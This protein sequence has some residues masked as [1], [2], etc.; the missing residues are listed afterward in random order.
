[1]KILIADDDNSARFYLEIMLKKWGYEVVIAKDGNSA[2]EILQ[3]KSTP[4]LAILDW[5]MP[6]MSGI[7]ICS[8]IRQLDH[9]KQLYILL[10]TAK[11][12]KEDIIAGLQ[13]GAD[14]YVTKP[15]DRDI[16][17][18][19]ILV[20]VRL[21]TLQDHLAQHLE[22]LQQALAKVNKLQGLVPI[23]SYCKKIRDDKNYWHQV[24]QYISEHSGAQFSH[25]ICPECK[26][27]VL[28]EMG[29]RKL[30]KHDNGESS[31]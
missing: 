29:S 20:G 26:A 24:E 6:G 23:C 31:N 17:R 22:D 5:M 19:R 25:G 27:K 18:A 21:A 8:K 15:V 16:L 3:S 30:A 12:S 7:D 10:L 14:D 1:M 28:K 11:G 4:R 13:A 9:G 2:W